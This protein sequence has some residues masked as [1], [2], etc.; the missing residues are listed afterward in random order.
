MRIRIVAVGRMKT[1]PER[2]MVN[3]YLQ[4]IDKAGRSLGFSAPVVSEI[5][6]SRAAGAG[7]RRRQEAEAIARA[8]AG[9]PIGYLLDE[10]G[11]HLSSEQFAAALGD[12]RTASAQDA[13]FVIGGADGLDETLRRDA[14]RTLCFGRLTWPHQLVRILLCE[15]LYRAMTILSGHP[16]HRG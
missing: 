10:R 1:G 14:P 5:A 8:L 11:A 9:E 12:M 3:R 4:R 6:E 2:D 15:Q 16:Y 13:V 7:Q